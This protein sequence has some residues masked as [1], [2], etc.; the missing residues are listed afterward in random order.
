MLPSTLGISENRSNVCRKCKNVQFTWE[1]RS[2]FV[3]FLLMDEMKNSSLTRGLKWYHQWQLYL[4]VSVFQWGTLL[5]RMC[6]NVQIWSV[7]LSCTNHRNTQCV[8]FSGAET[9]EYSKYWTILTNVKDW[10]LSKCVFRKGCFMSSEEAVEFCVILMN[11][12]QFCRACVFFVCLYLHSEFFGGEITRT[13]DVSC[14]LDTSHDDP[15][16]DKTLITK[17]V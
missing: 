15:P 16:G 5:L 13:S 6:G 9:W 17:S 7:F 10:R 3:V 1:S 2:R 4:C 11:D 12:C 14:P 8:S